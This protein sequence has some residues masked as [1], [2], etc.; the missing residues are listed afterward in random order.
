MSEFTTL[1]WSFTTGSVR[2][3]LAVFATL[4]LIFA[5]LDIFALF[6]FAKIFSSVVNNDHSFL[7]QLLR[8]LHLNRFGSTIESDYAVSIVLVVVLILLKSIGSLLTG[9]QLLT[10]LSHSYKIACGNFTKN[11]FDMDLT[12]IK[13][14]SPYEVFLSV[15]S[16]V[17]DLYITG[18]Y[19]AINAIVEGIIVSLIFGVILIYGGV[20]SFFLAVYFIFSFWVISK[21]TGAKIRV[22]SEKLSRS[23]LDSAT[24]IQ[25]TFEAVRETRIFNSIE[26]FLRKQ[27]MSVSSSAESTVTLQYIGYIPKIIMEST[28]MI[29]IAMFTLFLILTGNMNKA[30]AEVGFIIAMGSRIIPSL[31]RLQFG[32]NQLK[33]VKGSST[34]TRQL[35]ELPDFI[36]SGT[37]NDKENQ[38]PESENIRF[39]PLVE[40]NNVTYLYPKMSK[41]ALRDISFEVMPGESIGVV[42]RS[43]SGKS[44]LLD[45]LCGGLIPES[46]SAKISG[47]NIR[48]ALI[49]WD[50]KVGFVP[51]QIPIIDG[52]LRE[53]LLLG[54]EMSLFEKEDFDRVLQFAGLLSIAPS[55]ANLLDYG[56]TR[57]G[58]ELSGGQRQKLGIARALLAKPDILIMDEATSSLDAESEDNVTQSIKL[59]EGHVTLIVVAHR[60]TVVK[61]L[62]R[63]I[64]LED[65]K[66]IASGSYENLIQNSEAFKS[67]VSFSQL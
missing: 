36:R 32:L 26:F 24:V 60:L 40:M 57:S 20:P 67:L 27:K 43:G 2:I 49:K 23:N 46:G 62:K 48:K 64:M 25:T 13:A 55:G 6:L 61:D 54:R 51:Q 3:R 10:T 42:G 12:A 58:S 30:V 16:G 15:N 7:S 17:R 66:I 53:N 56:L 44:T 4:N 35:L 59:L 28:F 14:R 21:F 5:I 18:I 45:L 41:P 19:S 63:I 22:H 65:G 37:E 47:M 29:G 31:L 38:N 1:L 8:F 9:K 50:G 52:T 11:Y 33:Q 39:T 34:F